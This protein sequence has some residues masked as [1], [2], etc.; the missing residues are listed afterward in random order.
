MVSELTYMLKGIGDP[1]PVVVKTGIRGLIAAKTALNPFEV[2][3]TFRNILKEKPYEFRFALRILPIEKV[4]RT[5]LDEIRRAAIELSAK[6][7]E[8]ETF[9]VTVEKRF[10]TL[11]SRDLIEATAT[12]IQRK[13]SMNNPDRIL[14][15][16]VLG[17][18]TGISLIKPNDVI[19]VM[20]EKML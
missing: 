17:G 15:I 20:K 1:S 4:V 7:G 11:H 10:T 12:S 9:R 19:S 13:A 3:A 14:L 2:I 16:E 6:I 18:S 8:N 5:D